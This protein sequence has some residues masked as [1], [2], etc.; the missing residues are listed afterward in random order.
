MVYPSAIEQRIGFD[1]IRSR[2]KELCQGPLGKA[3]A[4]QMV[5]LTDFHRIKNLLHQT[6]ECRR[7]LESEKE[8]PP[9]RHDETGPYLGH[10]ALEGAYLEEEA[11]LLILSTLQN[12]DAC[13][14][15][16]VKHQSDYPYVYSLAGSLPDLRH[17]IQSIEN[18]FDDK[19]RLRDHATAELGKIRKHI[20]EEQSKIKRLT[21]HIF[22]H[23]VQQGWV[24]EGVSYTIREGRLVIPVLS[25]HKRKIRGFIMDE[26][27]TGHTV[28]IEPAE[29]LEAN[30]ELRDLWHAERREIIKVLKELTALLRNH[31]SDVHALFEFLGNLDFARAKARYAI[32]IMAEMPRLAEVPDL[33]WLHARH[34]LLFISLKGKRNVVPLTIDLTRTCPF[35]LVSGPN[36]GGKSVCL[37]TVGLL[38][39]MVQCGILPSMHERSTVGIFQSIFLD[40][41]DQQSIENDLSTYSSHLKNLGYFVQHANE[42]T[43]VLMDELGSGTDPNFGGGIA[44]AILSELINRKAWGIA[45]THY[46]N[47]KLFASHHA[48]I[49][50]GAMQFDT[51]KLEPLFTLEIG[52]PGSSFALEIARITGLPSTTIE[53]AEKIIGK[54]LTGLEALMKSITEEKQ[55]LDQKKKEMEALETELKQTRARYELLLH[56]L[57]SKKKEIL[58]R[59]KEEAAQLLRQTNREIEKTIRHIKENKAEKKETKKVRE[60]LQ[61]LQV[62]VKREAPA[63]QPAGKISVGDK[64][65]LI[66][67]EVTGTVL[68][69][70]DNNAYVQFGDLRSSVKL[71]QLIPS[72][73]AESIT[74]PPAGVHS[75]VHLMNKQSTFNPTLDI[76][77]KRV[78]EV[79][80]LLDQFVDQAILLSQPQLKIIHGKGEGVLRKVVR[81]YLKK[82][83]VVASFADEHADRGGD[84]ITWVVLK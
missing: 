15:F 46:Y 50:N 73:Q 80:P 6:L 54:E 66:G 53:K 57:E 44:E 70:K 64:V 52:K 48:G 49:R 61:Q 21:E 56:D 37:K 8:F 82:V 39:Y 19:G 18:K 84:G 14:R 16:F 74:K 63:E 45:T 81:D 34:P 12:A 10:A 9:T 17:V 25:E 31:L 83:K 36:A 72:H 32:E 67:Q 76:R 33:N 27:A 68:S 24:P 59:A 5:F 79:V 42:H 20:R 3:V 47:L 11:M 2:L 40:I 75:G 7:I 29:V 41:G 35:L 62:K 43:L 58:T 26:S 71:K 30:N 77:G 51:R 55:Q 13:R 22:R 60:G 28:F 4:D 65:R 1:Q 78:E 69:I 38:Q 23:A